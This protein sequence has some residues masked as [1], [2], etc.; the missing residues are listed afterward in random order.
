MAENLNDLTQNAMPGMIQGGGVASRASGAFRT[1]VSDLGKVVTQLKEIASLTQK[2]KNDTQRMSMGTGGVGSGGSMGLGLGGFS[3]PLPGALTKGGMA[4]EGGAMMGMG[5]LKMLN[6]AGA[7]AYGMMPD[8][9]DVFARN[10]LA[11]N[12]SLGTSMS[13]TSVA[14]M[15]ATMNNGRM[16]GITDPY[17]TTAT[18]AMRGYGLGNAYGREAFNTAAN[19]GVLTGQSAPS[20]ATTLST[21]LM[22]PVMGNRLQLLGINNV[23]LKSGEPVGFQK[24]MDQLF[25]RL[26][27]GRFKTVE[28]FNRELVGGRGGANIMYNIPD[29]E[30]QSLAIQYF[31]SKY[32]GGNLNLGG[33]SSK[34]IEAMGGGVLNWESSVRSLAGSETQKIENF[35][36]SLSKGAK[37]AADFAKQLNDAMDPNSGFLQ[38]LAMGRGFLEQFMG[39][40][41]GQSGLAGATLALDA[42]KTAAMGAAVAAG[43]MGGASALS[44]GGMMSGLGK[45]GKAVAGIGSAIIGTELVSGLHGA[46]IVESGSN[47]DRA[48]TVL[49]MAGVGAAT[50]ALL[51]SVIPGLGTAVGAVAGTVIGAGVG[52]Y[53]QSQYTDG[54]SQ[55]S[56]VNGGAGAPAVSGMTTRSSGVSAASLASNYIGRPYVAGGRGPKG[57]DCA[58]FVYWV[59]KK[60]G[61]N[62]PQVSWEQVKQGSPVGTLSEAKPGDLLFFHMPGGHDRDPGPMKINHVGIYAGKGMMVHASTP[63]SGTIKSKVYMQHLRAIRRIL[64]TSSLGQGASKVLSDALKASSIAGETEGISI[65]TTYSVMSSGVSFDTTSISSAIGSTSIVDALN[66][67]ALS[68]SVAVSAGSSTSTSARSGT[69]DNGGSA[70]S[71]SGPKWLAR[72]LYAKGLRGDTLQRVWAI[73]MRESSGRPGVDNA[74]LNR[75]GSV[76]YGLFQINSVHAPWLKKT[77][78]WTMD[79]MRDPNKAFRA[80]WRMS[81]HGQ[82]LSAWNIGPNAYDPSNSGKHTSAWQNWMAQ[83]PN[84]AHSAGIPGYA[85]GAWKINRDHVAW[86]HKDE[87]ILPASVARA[88]RDN[89][90][91]SM[92]MG[93]GKVE[94]HVHVR[95]TDDEAMKFARNVRGFLSGHQSAASIAS[96]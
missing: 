52:L 79:D 82:N 54:S 71:G 51:G 5:A 89:G 57:W 45:A 26:G 84:A 78:G 1:W 74:G 63:S 40:K 77:F 13:A 11:F 68:G 7:V 42:L 61:K 14:R 19:L 67:G 10:R 90:Q 18:L 87:M 47:V 83:F 80:M 15:T 94:I 2:I 55:Q 29:P 4:A 12:A 28:Q 60:L 44:K 39:T 81:Q 95:G 73:G 23:D 25:N 31:Q 66:S 20:V 8:T 46:S 38:G 69:V 34:A 91:G 72:F 62:L 48:G 17:L 70:P 93:S 76:D 64:D 16:M 96:T 33:T 32:R 49:G 21:G 59:F 58:G 85:P 75:N 35:G 92:Q 22:N 53:Q 9:Q 6:A 88:V 27:F 86:V 56:V 37:A 43:A 30:M 24:M 41:G 65:G 36:D 3:T 50:G